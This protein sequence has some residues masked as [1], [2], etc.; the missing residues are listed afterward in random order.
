MKEM[1]QYL[2]SAVSLA[3][4]YLA[5]LRPYLA[6]RKAKAQQRRS[7]EKMAEEWPH[8]GLVRT[9][10]LRELAEGA[11]GKEVE[12]FLR[13]NA[14]KAIGTEGYGESSASSFDLWLK[15]EWLAR[16]DPSPEALL[17]A[18]NKLSPIPP[19]YQ[20]AVDQDERPPSGPLTE[21]GSRL[22][23]WRVQGLREVG[24]AE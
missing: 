7:L 22:F 2:L 18:A 1:L 15:V 10:V 17:N 21:T 23:G 6:S 5:I 8:S 19:W 13:K 3:T 14:Q 12:E 24:R 11:D 20:D 9:F 4:F 16:H